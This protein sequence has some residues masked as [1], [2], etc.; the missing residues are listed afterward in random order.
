MARG[1]S[2][3]STP[4]RSLSTAQPPRAEV[5]PDDDHDAAAAKE[6]ESGNGLDRTA[7]LTPT[8]PPAVGAQAPTPKGKLT[9]KIAEARGLR[10]A[11]DPYVVAVFQR[12]ELISSGP[13][14]TDEDDD[15]AIVTAAVGAVAIQRQGSDTGRP[16]M[17]IPM[18]SRQSSSTSITDYN[19]FR[20]RTARKSF[21]NP[22]WDAEAAL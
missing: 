4:T 5:L 22:K 9:I 8:P 1:K 12:S 3:Q 16:P 6:N 21:S 10:K 14:A 13:R 18:R 20:N 15:S 17:A 19:T 2:G 7:T 11:Q